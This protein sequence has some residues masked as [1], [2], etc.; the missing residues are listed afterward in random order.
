MSGPIVIKYGG[1]LLDNLDKQK[2]FLDRISAECKVGKNKIILVHGGGKEISR[3]MENAGLKPKFING[4]R[5]T[6]AKTM[7][8]VSDALIKLNNSIVEQIKMLGVDAKGY[9]GQ[10]NHWLKSNPMKEL[11]QVGVPERADKQLLQP[12]LEATTLP[13]FYSVGE[14]S[15]GNKLNINADDFAMILALGLE[16]RKLIFLTDAGG[17][18]DKAGVL[19]PQINPAGAERLIMNGTIT[20]GMAVKIRACLQAISE[21]ISEVNIGQSIASDA[22]GLHVVNGTVIVGGGKPTIHTIQ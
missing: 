5:Y 19:I 2:I 17:V 14:D 15:E 13:V 1:S 8:V 7:D 9:S 20:D 22:Q 18:L 10:Q 16:A 3:Q 4:R 6:D 21:G 11:G 12:L